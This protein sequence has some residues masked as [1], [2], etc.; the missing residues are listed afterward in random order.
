MYSTLFFLVVICVCFSEA[1]NKKIKQKQKNQSAQLT[2][3][4]TETS[5]FTTPCLPADPSLLVWWRFFNVQEPNTGVSALSV[6]PTMFLTTPR[7]DFS[8]TPFTFAAWVYVTDPTPRN[9]IW[10]DWTNPWLFLFA[11]ENGEF[12]VTLRRNIDPST[13]GFG[14]IGN[15]DL[16]DAS[17]GTVVAEQWTYVAFTW[18]PVNNNAVA[19]VN[20]ESGV[21]V[22]ADSTLPNF[23]LQQN[24]HSTYQLGWKGDS[25]D[26]C[27]DGFLRELK[28]WNVALTVQDLL[29]EF[30]FGQY[31]I[32]NG[33]N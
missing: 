8:L 17:A 7:V 3:Q 4:Q 1:K 10:G 20:T 23:D 9:I 25:G 28:V 6:D 31:L 19:Y 33:L 22:Q 13:P 24:T 21:S 5:Y 16:I 30:Y 12:A 26:S 32:N 18:D 14:S 11:I 2:P 29:A 27:F 15:Q